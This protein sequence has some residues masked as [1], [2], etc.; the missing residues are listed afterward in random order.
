MDRLRLIALLCSCLFTSMLAAQPLTPAQVPK[1]LAPWVDWVLQDHKERACPW[2]YNSAG[3][4]RCAWPTRL[5]LDLNTTQGRFAQ[6][7]LVY[8]ESWVRLPGD[9]NLWPQEV[10]VDGSPALVVEREGRPMLRLGPGQH[11]VLGQFSWE[12]LPEAISI[13]PDAGLIALTV[14][15]KRVAYPEIEAADQLW[16]KE[17]DTGRKEREGSADRLELQVFRRVIDEVPL[18]L[19]TRLELDVAGNQREV[20]LGMALLPGLIPLRLESPLPARLEPDGRLRLQLRPGHWVMELAARANTDLTQLPLSPSPP[21]WVDTEIWV[22]DARNHLRLVEIEGVPSVDPRQTNLPPKWQSLPAYRLQAGDTM[23]FKVIRRGDPEPEPDKLSLQREMWL[24]FEGQGYTLHDAITGQ[25]TRGWR[26]ETQAPILL[27]RVAVEGQPQFI[28]SLPGSPKRGVEVR[29]GALNL[30]A[31]SRYEGKVG[32]FPATGWDHDFQKVSADL[33]LP[34]GWRLF[35]ATGVDNVPDTWLQRW[36]LLDLFLVLI[37]AL[38]VGRLWNWRFG[39]I[40]LVTLALLWHEPEAPRYIWLHLLA[41]IALLRVL[42]PGRLR[43]LVSF[44]RNLSL[45]V[46]VL[47]ALP[48]MVDQVRTGLYPQLEYPWQAVP[49]SRVAEPGAPPAAVPSETAEGARLEEEAISRELYD[50]ARRATKAAPEPPQLEQLDPKAKIQTGPG[51]PTWRWTEI[52]LS[53]NGPVERGQKVGL[54]LLPPPVNLLLNLL[55]VLLL[56]WMAL[57]MFGVSY[58]PRGGWQRL[59]AISAAMLLPPLVLA[60]IPTTTQAQDFPSPE[61]LE[62]L[63]T[64]LLK[65]PEC[66]PQCAESPRLR[67]EISPENLEIRMEVHAAEEVAIPLPAHGS[68][69]LPATVMVDG[70]EAAGLFRTPSAELWLKL[71]RGRHQVLLA[72]PLPKRQSLQLPLPLKPHRVEVETKG[73]RVEGVHEMGL[74]DAQLQFTRLGTEAGGNLPELEPA[75]LPPFVRVERTL[76]LGLDFR[77]ETRITRLSPVGT[78]VVLEVPLLQGESVTTADIR[79]VNG[80][81]LV[82]MPPNETV[83]GWGSVLEKRPEL[84]LTAPDLTAWTELWRV[85]VSPI[86]HVVFSGIPVVHHQDPQGRWLPEWRPWP[87]ESLAI[88]ITRPEGVAGQTLTVDRS[89]L[90][91]HPGQRAT[92]TTLSLELRSSQGGQHTLILPEEARLQAVTINGVAQPIRQEGRSVTL[93]VT[94]GQQSIM[95]AWRIPS[96]IHALFRTAEVDLATPS[97]NSTLT[98]KL[99]NDRWVLLTG[100]PRLGP[101]VLF[102]GVLAIIV[103]VAVGLGRIQLTPLKTR[104]WLLL[105]VGL[106][107]I[108]VWMALTVVGW[109]LA[110]GSRARIKPELSHRLF[111]AIQLGLGLLTLVA[112]SFLF[113][114]IQQGLLGLPE[115]QIAG[116]NSSA[117]DLNWYQD[118]SPAELPQAWTASVPLMVYR[119]L[120]LGW[121]LWLAFALLHWLRWGWSC[122]TTHGLWRPLHLFKRKAAQA[123]GET[124]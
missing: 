75:A 57:L 67:L 25:M 6:S 8:A 71:T 35:S 19:L 80:R 59:T 83:F 64:R 13:P 51:L 53:W 69:W 28:T 37:A 104:H 7:W 112:L 121:A 5:E 68:T 95:L 74:A 27:G 12:R 102:W 23:A 66:L 100:G 89:H 58:T 70:A 78:A 49:A 84:G 15:G 91:V 108:P 105:G 52:A 11:E 122:Y 47:I 93:P 113:D 20:L 39:V 44:Y 45:V 62:E 55:R 101:A 81:V 30:T 60:F 82:N 46:L 16:L 61:L 40:A 87:G 88:A 124:E 1:P 4:H 50:Y 114:A 26:L 43:F 99:G 73:W 10:R 9:G 96:G 42:G 107:Q 24:D 118:R 85:D 72:G 22:F 2:L 110:L 32:S 106:S 54:I 97:V 65:P 38:A 34:P 119:L 14:N 41:A 18:E 98:I 33:H 3:E 48:F 76:H 21:P 63:K 86:W 109:L 56:T 123:L 77:V 79:V 94:P 29:R 17:R 111:N 120:M 92:D 90:E 116:N 103:L 115:M 117:Y 36:T 31:D